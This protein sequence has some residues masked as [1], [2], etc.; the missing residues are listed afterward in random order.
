[1][2]IALRRASLKHLISEAEM[3]PTEND[4]TGLYYPKP[5]NDNPYVESTGLGNVTPISSPSAPPPPPPPPPPK[6]NKK[7]Q[8]TGGF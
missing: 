5:R 6:K 4:Q 7:T 2:S 3:H 8:K 1:M